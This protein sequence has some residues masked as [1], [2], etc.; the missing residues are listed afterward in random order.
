M[1]PWKSLLLVLFHVLTIHLSSLTYF[2]SY[3]SFKFLTFYF[4]D[5]YFLKKSK[6]FSGIKKIKNK[7]NEK[8]KEKKG[9]GWW[10][11]R[12]KIYLIG[13]I[14]K[15]IKWCTSNFSFDSWKYTEWLGEKL[16]YAICNLHWNLKIP[17]KSSGFYGWFYQI[18]CPKLKVLSAP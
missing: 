5:V 13:A 3:F 1:L 9:N 7:L 8:M 10:I 18:Q 14:L 12:C 11:N 2:L 15:K 16:N 4:K 17:G 6:A